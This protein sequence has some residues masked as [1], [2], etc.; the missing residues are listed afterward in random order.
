MDKKCFIITPIGRE[1]SDSRRATDGLIKTVLR[2]VLAELG[3]EAAASHEMST[4]GSIT[5]QVI[6]RLLNDDLVV[7]NLTELNPNVMYELAVRHAVGLPVVVLAQ[8]GTTIPFDISDERTIFYANDLAGAEELKDKLSD[9]IPLASEDKE[10]DNPIYRVAKSKIMKD[11]AATDDTQR[12]I[13]DRLETIES[14]I[15]KMSNRQMGSTRKI[16]DPY[17]GFRSKY[18]FYA[19]IDCGE[20][21]KTDIRNAIMEGC[22]LDQLS[23]VLQDK[24]LK[25]GFDAANTVSQETLKDAI[26]GLGAKVT[27]FEVEVRT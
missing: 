18:S 10:P 20:A 9:T 17:P 24:Q 13:L 22:D 25:I 4:P 12:Y 15:S 27:L 1:N 7:A 11:V 5:R 23:S 21:S 26:V 14:A 8:D 19:E 6:E 2:P 16:I 3:Y